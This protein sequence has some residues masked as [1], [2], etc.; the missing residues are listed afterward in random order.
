MPR[1]TVEPREHGTREHGAREHSARERLLDAASEL[2]YAEGIHTVGIDRIIEKAGV[3]KASLYNT[4]GSKDELVR[5]Y[6]Q[7]RHERSKARI[8]AALAG[9]TDPRDKILAV[10]E[11][12]AR[13]FAQPDFHGCAFANASAESQ[14]G[15]V[16][17]VESQHYRDWLR[18]LFAQ[19]AAEAGAADPQLLARQLML[20][21]DGANMAARMDNYADAAAV[22]RASVSALLDSALP[23]TRQLNSSSN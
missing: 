23:A 21:Y 17:I 20:Q 8:D 11:A 12:Q 3:A 15:D 18:G 16:A 19:Y 5:A 7:Q 22:C 4:Y 14:P 6:L 13:L 9:K 1:T 10:F 2:F